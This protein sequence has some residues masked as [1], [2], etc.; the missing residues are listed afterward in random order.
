MVP[1]AVLLFAGFFPP[2]SAAFQTNQPADLVIGQADMIHNG[3][4][5]VA[6]WQNPASPTASTLW[7]PGQLQVSGGKLYVAD[8][9]NNRVLIYN[10]FPAADTPAAD[11]VVGQSDMVS[12]YRNQYPPDE[13]PWFPLANSV[14]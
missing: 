1:A 9:H 11:I 3:I 10:S 4:N 6:D 2:E 14:Y 7:W 13:P 8:Y 12:N 5:Q